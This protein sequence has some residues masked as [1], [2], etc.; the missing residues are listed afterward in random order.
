MLDI[1]GATGVLLSRLCSLRPDLD[2]TLND[3]SEQACLAAAEQH[4]LKTVTGSFS[5]LT[6][7]QM[8]YDCILLVDVL[9]YEPQITEMWNAISSP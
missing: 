7:R 1:G 9:Y 3:L 8:Q 5:T 2:L 6:A 4:G